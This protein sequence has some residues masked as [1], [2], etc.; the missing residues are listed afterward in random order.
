MFTKKI[1]RQKSLDRLSNPE[2]LDGA[3]EMISIKSWALLL[4][5]LTIIFSFFIWIAFNTI[6]QEVQCEGLLITPNTLYSVHALKTGFVENISLHSRDSVKTGD[7]LLRVISVAD[8]EKLIDIDRQ[9]IAVGNSTTAAALV[10]RLNTVS[11][12]YRA[13]STVVSPMDGSLFELNVTE[14]DFVQTGDKLLT[15]EMNDTSTVKGNFKIIGLI[16]AEHVNTVKIGNTVLVAPK[17]IDSKEYGYLLGTVNKISKHPLS[18]ERKK[19]ITKDNP[20]MVGILHADFFEIDILPQ[21]EN[22]RLLWTTVHGASID[23]I[24]TTVCDVKV[25]TS[26][27]NMLSFFIR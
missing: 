5:L 3:V 6:S 9:R 17:N 11:E 8:K 19:M 25:I 18:P 22:N 16:P 10:G 24:Q 4:L 23:H 14:G 27:K 26:Q 21:T 15:I 12:E 2:E 20:S 13:R 7:V 1:F